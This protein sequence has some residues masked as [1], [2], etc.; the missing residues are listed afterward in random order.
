MTEQQTVERI[1][2]KDWGLVEEPGKLSAEAAP[3]IMALL[4]DG[5]P[6][7]RELAIYCLNEVGGEIARQ[8]FLKAL[9][10]PD[11][12]VRSAACQFLQTNHDREDLPILLGELATNEDEYVR[13]HVALVIGRIGESGVIATL[14][15]RQELELDADASHGF[16]LALIRL[17]DAESRQA[18]FERLQQ[19][20]PKQIA[21]ALRD[22]E[23]I[24]DRTMLPK[25]M[26]L[27]DDKREAVKVGP[28]GG[29]HFIRVCDVVVNVL[30][31]V[32]D[33]PF[34]FKVNQIRQYSQ[35]QLDNARSVVSKI[36]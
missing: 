13:E 35:E 29:A 11:D 9:K 24:H 18:Y 27:L 23:Y 16:S 20:E 2:Q 31:V 32:L 22:F 34:S 5:D 10:D 28:S 7:V 3:A 36:K 21:I 6:Q 25:I 15:A 1:R 4:D 26:P 8:G 14:K 33:H 19:N 17:G 12:Q 30:D